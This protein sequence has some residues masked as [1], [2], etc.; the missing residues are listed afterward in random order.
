MT[1]IK[2][3]EQL[4]IFQNLTILQINFKKLKLGYLM[5]DEFVILLYCYRWPHRFT[6]PEYDKEN[7]I[8]D[9]G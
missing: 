3:V 2:E 9:I 5:T 4:V 7:I 1:L 8:L 6:E